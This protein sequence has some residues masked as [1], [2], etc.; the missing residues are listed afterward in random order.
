MSEKRSLYHKFPDYR[1]ELDPSKARVAVRIGGERVAETEQALIVRESKHAPVTYVPFADVNSDLLEAT[2]HTTFCPFK[3][4]ASYWTVRVGD[5]AYENV[6]WGYLDPFEE[7][8]GI[9][10]YVAFYPD[11]AELVVEENPT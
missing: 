10:G 7:V 1:V 5:H 4:D 9:K 6:M 2:D 3:G 8:A 11:R